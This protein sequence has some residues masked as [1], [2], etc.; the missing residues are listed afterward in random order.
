MLGISLETVEKEGNHFEL[1]TNLKAVTTYAPFRWQERLFQECVEDNLPERCNT[2]ADF[3][4][5]SK[6]H[7]PYLAARTYTTISLQFSVATTGSLSCL[8]NKQIMVV[9]QVA[10]EAEPSLAATFPNDGNEAI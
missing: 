9:A 7:N 10:D 2:Q 3:E 5:T 6:V 4:K 1:N 8:H